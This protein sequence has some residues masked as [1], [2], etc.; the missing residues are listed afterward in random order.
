MSIHPRYAPD[1]K[2][3][4]NDQ[5]IPAALRAA[6]TSVSYEDGMQAAD[7]VEVGLANINLRWLQSHIRGLGFQPFPSRVNLPVAGTIV[8]ATEGSFDIDN[9]LSLAIGYAPNPLEEMF[10][11]ELTGVEA[12]FPNG[13]VPTMTLVAHDYLNRLSRG[14]YARGFGFIPD[15]LI[16]AILSAENLLLPTI[17]PAIIAGS[18]ALAV[19]NVIFKSGG[20]KQTSSDLALL[21]EIAKTYDADFWV[22]GD[23][24]YLS[25]FM[26]EYTPRLTLVW[27]QNLL[28]FSPRVSTIGQ[29][30]GVA[31]KFTLREIPLDFLVTVFWDFDRE[32]LGISIVPG[33]AAFSKTIVGAVKTIINKTIA[34]PADITTSALEITHELRSKINNRLTGRGSAIGDPRIRAGAVIRLEGLGPDF[35]GD[36]R[37]NSATHSIDTSGYRTTFTVSKEIL[38]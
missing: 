13:G 37:V 27:G 17:D 30:A 4:I 23:V 22:E 18:T 6:I 20:R 15:A 33:D 36:Y 24:L 16:A 19:L 32:S 21:E 3:R 34:S 14:S 29:V 1:F 9:K 8:A 31:A 7:R 35:S 2:I 5:E 10:R 12:S 25:R 28:D 26:K 11:G 38:P